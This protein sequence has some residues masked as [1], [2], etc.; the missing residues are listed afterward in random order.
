MRR[1]SLALVLTLLASALY[2]QNVPRHASECPSKEQAQPPASTSDED[3]VK[4]S[5][6]GCY[7]TCP[8]YEVTIAGNG[9]VTWYGKLY[10]YSVGI[11]HSQINR[12][13]ARALINQFRQPKFWE[14]CGRYSA[15]IT[16]MPTT[17]IDLQIGGRSKSV[18]NYAGSAPEWVGTFEES[19]DAASNSHQWRHGEPKT[20][21][22]GNVSEDG[23]MPKPGVTPLMRAARK[24]D[25]AAIKEELAR[26]GNVDAVDA[27]G[28]TA[29]MYGAR[30]ESDD[31]VRILLKAGADPNHK[32]FAGDTPLMAA[33]TGRQFDETLR[34]AGVDVNA[35][36]QK[37][38]SALMILAAEGDADEVKSA[39]DAGADV[40][41]KDSEGRTPLDYLQ[42]ADCGKSPIEE[43][44]FWETGGCNQLNRD[45]V[46]KITI[47]LKS[48]NPKK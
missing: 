2:G 36:N 33:A 44:R 16:D 45:D 42:L 38:V 41:A 29:L 10:I 3:F 15:N 40:F 20:E 7:G 5:R 47:L 35:K 18:S 34:K 14:L 19:I 25:V 28:W 46:E 6:G 30:V 31:P 13:E 27:S 9:D 39:L 1:N 21:P 11:I 22:L 8:I 12:D 23:Y 24:G 48:A 17:D 26:G 37:G 4:L 43:Q 32:S